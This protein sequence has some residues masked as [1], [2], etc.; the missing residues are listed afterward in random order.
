MDV[1]FYGYELDTAPGAV[2]TPRPA[3]ERLVDAALARLDGPARVA[4]VGTGSGAVGIVLALERPDVDV[5]ATDRCAKAVTL[6]RQNVLRHGVSCRV[7][8]VL[9]DLLDGVEGPFDLVL[10]NL[11][12]L[13]PG[14]EADFP[15]EPAGAIVST[16]DGL[17]HYRRLAAQ[18]R[19]VLAPG[20]LL[21]VQLHGDVHELTPAA[22]AA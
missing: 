12:Y 22:L 3:T 13:P 11:P 9:T 20:G 15:G 2:F 14:R 8:V 16:G 1:T 17:D 19:D 7:H 21:L 4:D 6:A 5:V 10:A 18:S